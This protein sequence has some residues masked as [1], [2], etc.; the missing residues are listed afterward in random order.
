MVTVGGEKQTAVRDRG[1]CWPRTDG[2]VLWLP[3]LVPCCLRSC[4]KGCCFLLALL[5]CL[6]LP[7]VQVYLLHSELEE[8]AYSTARAQSIA[9]HISD[10]G[11]S[12]DFAWKRTSFQRVLSL[13]PSC[14]D[15]LHSSNSP[16]VRLV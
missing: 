10:V 12:S 4:R 15:I 7:F 5:V 13:A 9:H 8:T 6:P 11:R 1:H 14:V 16:L 3:P 2:C